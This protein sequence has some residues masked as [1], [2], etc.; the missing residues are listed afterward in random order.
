VLQEAARPLPGAR[1]V[2]RE[3]D[4]AIRR[5][6]EGQAIELGWERDGRL[7][8]TVAD[9]LDM[10]LRKTSWYSVILP[11]RLGCLAAH[12]GPI[13]R[14]FTRFGALAGAVLQIG[15]D[16]LG[17][18]AAADRTGKDWGDDVLEGK[19]SLPV[20]YCLATAP[21]GDRIRLRRLLTKPRDVRKRDDAQ[22]VAE[23]LDRNG[24]LEYARRCASRLG[25]AAREELARELSGV[26]R[27]PQAALLSELVCLLEARVAPGGGGRD[28]ASDTQ[29]EPARD[30]ARAAGVT[31]AFR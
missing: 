13:G 29:Q 6:I 20:I 26:P 9:Y 24:G 5:T 11:C 28:G 21:R 10:V 3:V 27:T 19:R 4:T 7:D 14:R 12:T 25:A 22:W 23:L 16:I 8:V 15:D 2:P 31:R 1:A 18:T 30:V 17:L